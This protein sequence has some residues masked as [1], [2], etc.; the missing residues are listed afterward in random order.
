MLN[1]KA[2]SI[3]ELLV[4]ITI[5]AII[6]VFG[7]PKVDKWL[8]DREISNEVNKFVAYFEENQ[9][10]SR[11]AAAII[12]GLV[13]WFVGIGSILSM[14][15][16]ETEYFLGERNFM[17]SIIYLT[18]NIL[19]PLGGMLVAIFA[20][21]FFKPQLA[22]EELSVANVNIFRTWRFFIKFVSPVLVAAVFVYQLLG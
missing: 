22:M 19:M 16:W 5:I 21:W 3:L 12:L 13:I 11:S 9:I 15:S 7:Y 1:R 14:N 8:T 2:F 18:F 20:G 6:S 17:D 4:V 10:V